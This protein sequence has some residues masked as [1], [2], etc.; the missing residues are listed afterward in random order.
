MPNPV[1]KWFM[2][3]VWRLQQVAQVLTLA[4]LALNLSLQVW[5]YVKWRN[6]WLAN[7]ITGV[8]LFIGALAAAIWTFA[9]LWDIK[10]KMWREQQAVLIERNPYAKEKMAAKEVALYEL[11]WLPMLEKIGKDDPKIQAAARDLKDWVTKLTELDPVL[12]NDLKEVYEF[13]RKK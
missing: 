12:E 7:P 5:G 2:L 10:F 6:E 1:K 8:L 13:I 9:I 4:L 11:L 3:Q